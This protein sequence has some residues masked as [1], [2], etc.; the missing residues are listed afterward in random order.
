M[1]YSAC[2]FADT[3]AELAADFELP[4]VDTYAVFAADFDPEAEGAGN[5]ILAEQIGRALEDRRELLKVLRRMVDTYGPLTDALNPGAT[6]TALA[7]A[8]DTLAAL[9]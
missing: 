5:Q 3:I 9:T 2:D 7:E 4:E 6:D 1:S 8:R